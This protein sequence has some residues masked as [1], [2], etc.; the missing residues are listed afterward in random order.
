MS[1]AKETNAE[2][3][4]DTAYYSHSMLEVYRKSPARFEAIYIKEIL[5]RPPSKPEQVLG[6]LVH[7]LVLEPEKI[8][9]MFFCAECK[10]RQGKTWKAAVE[11]AAGLNIEAV[12]LPWLEKA[13]QMAAAVHVHPLA[14]KLLNSDGVVEQPLRWINDDGLQLKCK[15]DLVIDDGPNGYFLCNELKSSATPTREE[16]ANQAYNLGY[17]RQAAHYLDVL[18]AQDACPG[19][20]IFIFIVVDNEKPFDVFTYQPDDEFIELGR[21]ENTVTLAALKNSLNR[22]EWLAKNQN[23][24][25]TLQLPPRARRKTE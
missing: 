14:S 3:H 17:H 21:Y 2:Y 4:A 11:F 25:Q 15:P 24:L 22:N 12:P 7:C 18:T 19:L 9:A 16:F 23:E 6:S 1:Q 13:K 8:D 20:F 5:P 10:V